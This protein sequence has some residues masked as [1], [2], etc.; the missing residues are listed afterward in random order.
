LPLDYTK[1]L[2]SNFKRTVAL[3]NSFDVNIVASIFKAINDSLN[4]I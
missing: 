1:E 2:G 3:G 4:G